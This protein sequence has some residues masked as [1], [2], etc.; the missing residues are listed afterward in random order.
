MQGHGAYNSVGFKTNAYHEQAQRQA[1]LLQQLQAQQQQVQA[2]QAQARLQVLQQQ[3]RDPLAS[4]GLNQHRLAAGKPRVKASKKQRALQQQQ[5]P[6][7]QE[8]DEEGDDVGDGLEEGWFAA[9]ST[10]HLE[11]M[12]LRPHPDPIAGVWKVSVGPNVLGLAALVCCLALQQ[13]SKEAQRHC[14]IVWLAS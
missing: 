8:G 6:G 10:E 2:A 11:K 9:V 3:A 1:Q 14:E 4:L 12:G 13:A 5:L 7:Q